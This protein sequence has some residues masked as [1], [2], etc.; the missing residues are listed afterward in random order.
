MCLQGLLIAVFSV[1]GLSG[2]F[3]TRAQ[4][5]ILKTAKPSACCQHKELFIYLLR[6]RRDGMINTIKLASSDLS[7]KHSAV[8]RLSNELKGRQ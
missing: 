1:I 4:C 6:K 7:D 2:H 8:V 5:L 3:F